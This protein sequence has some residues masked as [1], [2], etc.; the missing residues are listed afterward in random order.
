MKLE[1]AR[2]VDG[3][4]CKLGSLVFRT[5][6]EAE[7]ARRVDSFGCKLGF[8]VFCTGNEAGSGVAPPARGSAV[9]CVESR[10]SPRCCCMHRC[11]SRGGRCERGRSSCCCGRCRCGL[12]SF[13]FTSITRIQTHAAMY[14]SAD[15]RGPP[16]EEFGAFRDPESV[17]VSLLS[18]VMS[19]VPSWP[20]GAGL[21]RP[22]SDSVLA[23]LGMACQAQA[24]RQQDAP[25]WAHCASGRRRDRPARCQHEAGQLCE[26]LQ[27]C[28]C[29]EAIWSDVMTTVVCGHRRRS[30][31]SSRR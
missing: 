29:E 17:L 4:G 14:V 18:H 24:N 15:A 20:A 30:S 8:L 22:F 27:Q 9:S 26:H 10:H 13:H 21:M 23:S 31:C 16:I 12:T 3:F 11:W 7:R 5:G 28:I 6:D 25:L 2:R 19:T 1:R